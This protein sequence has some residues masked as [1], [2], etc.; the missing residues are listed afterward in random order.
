MYGWNLQAGKS[1][2]NDGTLRATDGAASRQ[3][4]V[5]ASWGWYGVKRLAGAMFIVILLPAAAQASTNEDGRLWLAAI[6]QGSFEALDPELEKWRWWLEG[7]VRFRDD[8]SRFV[9]GFPRVGLGYALFPN[10]TLWLGYAFIRTE[11]PGGNDSNEHRIFQQLIWSRSFDSIGLASRTRLEQR[12]FDTGS[13]VGWRLRQWIK[14]TLPIQGRL[15]LAVNDEVF[16]HLNGTDWGARAGLDQNRFFIG[17]GWNFDA[18]GRYRMEVGYLNQYVDGR[19]ANQL[20]HVL[21][22]NLLV[23]Y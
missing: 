3:R 4:N 13:D 19:A 22:L 15:S 7:Q 11:P 12:F 1:R 23:S 21:S 16:V 9:Q 2:R 10:T 20:N 14:F 6:S 8:M 18:A 5:R 17:P